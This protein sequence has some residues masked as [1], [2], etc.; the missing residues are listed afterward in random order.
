MKKT[1]LSAL[2]LCVS[3]VSPSCKPQPLPV[4]TKSEEVSSQFTITSTPYLEA[5]I[6]ELL[7]EKTR[8]LSEYVLVNAKEKESLQE[9]ELFVIANAE[10]ELEEKIYYIRVY[11]LKND[12]LTEGRVL[13]TLHL[14]VHPSQNGGKRDVLLLIDSG[15]DGNVDWGDNPVIYGDIMEENENG[16][17]FDKEEKTG[18]EHKAHYQ[19]ELE[20]ILDK[21]ITF[22]KL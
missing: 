2:L 5:E 10:V 22:Y 19:K 9:T 15:L 7:A 11:D 3:F 20:N 4:E 12:K 1:T 16:M 21:L 13:D 17:Y 14:D 8:R 6:D 18:L